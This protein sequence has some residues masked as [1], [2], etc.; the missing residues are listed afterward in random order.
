LEIIVN[1]QDRSNLQQRLQELEAQIPVE[2]TPG[3]RSGTSFPVNNDAA[4]ALPKIATWFHNLPDVLKILAIAVAA[5]VGF[6]LLRT[7]LQLVFS[8]ITL[9]VV[10]GLVYFGYKFWVT[11]APRE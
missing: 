1:S 8:L 6:A 9:V 4:V 7:V 2:A 5:V 11:P 3:E 10:G